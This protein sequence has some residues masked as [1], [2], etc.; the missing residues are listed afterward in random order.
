MVRDRR[1]VIAVVGVSRERISPLKVAL[2]H[3]LVNTLITDHITAKE[4]LREA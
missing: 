4:L 2:T 1:K 3:G